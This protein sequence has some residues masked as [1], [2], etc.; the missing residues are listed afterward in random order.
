MAGDLADG[1]RIVNTSSGVTATAIPG[2]G[3]YPGAE[4]FIDQITKVAAFEF[5]AR[6]ITVNAV[7]PGSTATG[8]FADMS[9]QQ[10]TQANSAFAL[11]RI[12]QPRD[13][14]GMVAFLTSADAEFVT[15][16][17]IYRAAGQTGPIRRG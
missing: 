9:E 1:G 13:V 2:I 17:V 12:G 15:G 3:L 11:G 4:A 6:P 10:L 14:A 8:P 16:Q 5:A 7:N